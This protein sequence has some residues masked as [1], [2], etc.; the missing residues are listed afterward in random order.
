M[1]GITGSTTFVFFMGCRA[2]VQIFAD[3]VLTITPWRECYFAS[4]ET[5]GV[6]QRCSVTALSHTAHP[7]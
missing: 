2:R 4:D 1:F 3:L 6:N 5:A 7:K